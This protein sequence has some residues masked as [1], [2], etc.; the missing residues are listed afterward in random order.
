[1]WRLSGGVN[2]G[3]LGLDIKPYVVTTTLRTSDADGLV[4]YQEDQFSLPG[5]DILLSALLPQ[6]RMLPLPPLPRR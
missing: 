1:M 2:I 3:P 5:W 6:L 4:V